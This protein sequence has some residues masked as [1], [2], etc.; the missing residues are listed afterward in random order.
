MS[1]APP[2]PGDYV[3][4]N[5]GTQ[6]M[7]VD[8]PVFLVRDGDGSERECS[9][10]M[11]G[12]D[13]EAPAEAPRPLDDPGLAVLDTGCGGTMNGEVWA[14]EFK[15]ELERRG[16]TWG[17]RPCTGSAES[18]GESPPQSASPGPSE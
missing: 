11:A 15:N 8:G 6:S 10:M 3:F 14:D 7:S 12:D 13:D 16:L 1:A 17:S 2:P 4:V 18:E 5:N 9:V